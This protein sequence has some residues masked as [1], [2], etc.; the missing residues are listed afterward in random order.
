MQDQVLLSM[1]QKLDDLCE[2]VNYFKDEPDVVTKSHVFVAE[3]VEYGC[4]LCQHHNLPPN[5]SLFSTSTNGDEEFKCKM[6][7]L[8][9]A[10]PE[11]R[12]MS[13]LSGWA[14][15]SYF[16]IQRIAELED[17]IHTN[18]TNNMIINKLRKDILILEQ[19]LVRNFHA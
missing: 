17:I 13:D 14:L 12:G 5:A 7:L 19:K 9:E 18:H 11:K 4:N 8:A 1:Q 16:D 3:M 15:T 2:Q 10:E 6:P